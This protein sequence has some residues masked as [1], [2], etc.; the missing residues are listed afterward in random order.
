MIKSIS[1][2]EEEIKTGVISTK[3]LKE[4]IE[5]YTADGCLLLNNVLPADYVKSLNS[6]FNKKYGSYFKDKDH[7]DALQV[8]HQ[9]FM[10]SVKMETPFNSQKI[11]ANPLA[12]PIIEV[13][14]D[15]QCI[16]N[17]FG[18]VV[19]LPGAGDQPVHYDHPS[20]FPE[21]DVCEKNP[22]HA[23]TVIFPLVELNEKTGTTAMMPGSHRYPPNKDA[24]Y[25]LTYDFPNAPLGSCLLMDY[26]L[27]HYGVANRSDNVRPI[28]Y[29]IYSRPWFRDYKNYSKQSALS[30][31]K[32]DYNKIPDEYKH[33][34][35][36]AKLT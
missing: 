15:K 14:L 4:A 19:S 5:I 12:Y 26:R 11:Y 25:G 13:L 20:L 6:S 10:V 8:G 31:S 3:N 29:N 23:I 9:R 34:F 2:S 30:I 21:S 7:K 27:R 16:I 1:F 18:S 22:S 35:L 33:L 24:D 17:G 32:K 28:L 36:F